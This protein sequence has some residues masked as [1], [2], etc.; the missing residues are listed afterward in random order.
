MGTDMSGW[1]EVRLDEGTW[2]GVQRL[3][4]DRHYALYAALFG[5]RNSNHLVPLAARRGLPLHVS[6]ES[7]ELLGGEKPGNLDATWIG[8]WELLPIPWNDPMSWDAIEIDVIRKTAHGLVPHCRLRYAHL[9][10]RDEHELLER[11]GHFEKGQYRYETRHIRDE[12]DIPASWIT[13]M[14]DFRS[15]VEDPYRCRLVAY[16]Y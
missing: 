6:E 16:F 9:L 4:I 1:V 13:L 12:I 10:S 5:V 8:L 15:R 11:A 14:D 7:L 3:N 2:K